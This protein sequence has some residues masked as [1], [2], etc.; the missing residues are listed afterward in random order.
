MKIII[1][2]FISLA[3]ICGFFSLLYSDSNVC[4]NSSLTFN[5]LLNM[6]G[7]LKNMNCSSEHL[8]LAAPP[9]A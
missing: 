2:R 5:L 8:D 4:I 7:T 1:I 6:N 9:L 3:T